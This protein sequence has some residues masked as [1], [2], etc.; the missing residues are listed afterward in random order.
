MVPVV[1]PETAV[2][3]PILEDVKSIDPIA[4]APVVGWS[5]LKSV[6]RILISWSFVNLSFGVNLNV[7]LL[8]GSTSVSNSPNSKVV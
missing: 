2:P 5:V 3:T 8:N 1:N 4:V 7:F 6:L